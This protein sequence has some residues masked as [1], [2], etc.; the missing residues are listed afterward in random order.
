MPSIQQTM[1]AALEMAHNSEFVSALAELSDVMTVSAAGNREQLEAM[2][3]DSDEEFEDEKTTRSYKVGDHVLLELIDGPHMGTWVK[4]SITGHARE[5]DTYSVHLWVG[6]PK[7]RDVAEVPVELLRNATVAEMKLAAKQRAEDEAANR[8]K[9]LAK[10][11]AEQKRQA[12]AFRQKMEDAKR[13]ADEAE[14]KKAMQEKEDEAQKEFLRTHR[15]ER[16]AAESAKRAEAAAR[17]KAIADSL[18][19][20]PAKK[21]AQE[22]ERQ[23]RKQAF[24]E[25]RKAAAEAVA[26]KKEET[27]A[28]NHEKTLQR[29]EEIRNA[30]RSMR[31]SRLK[32]EEKELELMKT[33]NKAELEARLASKHRAAMKALGRL[34]QKEYAQSRATFKVKKYNGQEVEFS[35]RRKMP[36]KVVMKTAANKLGLDYEKARFKL[37]GK[38]IQD[39]DTA[40]TLK[41]IDGSV[42]YVNTPEAKL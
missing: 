34:H 5:A 39:S 7:H 3:E 17:K 27:K 31:E 19:A 11:A 8:Q 10:R 2:S 4:G 22:K 24:D 42:I 14:L 13:L 21:A 40:G 26:R 38:R 32:A 6:P 28:R 18:A 33:L 15:K 9:M 37:N 35:V 23:A 41:I 1:K 29:Q 12:D 20:E 36:M 16:I 25:K 30:I